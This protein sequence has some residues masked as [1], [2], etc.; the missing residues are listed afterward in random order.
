MKKRFQFCL[1]VCSTLIISA[2]NLNVPLRY[3]KPSNNDTYTIDYLFQHDGVKV[4]RFY[5]MGNYVYFTTR[6][7]ATSIHADS[8]K[9][10]TITI[11][12]EDSIV[13]PIW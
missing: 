12:R 4:Y 3:E 13:S 11:H 9:Q 10:R 5:D 8:T 2:C 7:D 1:L 6:G